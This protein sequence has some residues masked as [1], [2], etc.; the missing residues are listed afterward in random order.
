MALLLPRAKK[1]VCVRRRM[2][3]VVCRVGKGDV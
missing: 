3:V 1:E 2:V